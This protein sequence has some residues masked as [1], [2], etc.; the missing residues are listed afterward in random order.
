MRPREVRDWPKVMEIIMGVSLT[1][2]LGVDT[3][4][5]HSDQYWLQR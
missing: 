4:V 3:G 2:D 1:L 5:Q